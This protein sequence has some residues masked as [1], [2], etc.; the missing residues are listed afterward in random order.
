M[1]VLFYTVCLLIEV[2]DCTPRPGE[3]WITA[4]G[5]KRCGK[6]STLGYVMAAFNVF[7]DFFLLAI[8]VPVVWKL[9]LALRRKVG[10]SLVFM[11]GFL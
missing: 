6:E 1:I 4:Q 9:Q 10:I 7:S 3:T 5:S 11:T 8:P 2:I